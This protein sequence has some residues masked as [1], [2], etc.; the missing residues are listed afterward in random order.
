M[1]QT[2]PDQPVNATERAVFRTISTLLRDGI[3]RGHSA[4]ESPTQ[5]HFKPSPDGRTATQHVDCR[6]VDGRILVE[7][8]LGRSTNVPRM[9]MNSF[10]EI[11]ADLP[12]GAVIPPMVEGTPFVPRVTIPIAAGR[13]MT[14]LREMRIRDVFVDMERRAKLLQSWYRERTSSTLPSALSPLADR[15][16]LVPQAV[17]KS[18]TEQQFVASTLTMLDAG[19]CTISG[20]TLLQAE[21]AVALVAGAHDGP[22]VR[23]LAGEL[24][25]K[26]L[27]ELAPIVGQAGGLLVMSVLG[28]AAGI[29]PYDLGR[30]MA[31]LLRDLAARR[32]PVLF[33]GLANDVNAVFAP[34]GVEPNPLLPVALHAPE[35]EV[36]NLVSFAV[37]RLAAETG[38]GVPE[39]EMVTR[40]VLANLPLQTPAEAVRVAGAAVRAVG[41][42]ALAGTLDPERAAACVKAIVNREEV[43]GGSRSQEPRPRSSP[44]HHRLLHALTDGELLAEHKRLIIGQ[45]AAIDQLYRQLASQ[46]RFGAPEKPLAALMEG[47]PG[48]GK[49]ASVDF[50]ARKLGMEMVYI[51]AAS[52]GSHMQAHSLLLGSGLGIVNS[53]MP[54]KFEVASRSHS[55]LEIADLDHAPDDVRGSVV[56]LFLQLMDR[57]TIQTATGRTLT[58]S[59]MLVCYTCNLPEGDDFKMRRQTGFAFDPLTDGEIRERIEG[60]LGGLFSAAFLSRVGAPI[61]FGP[62]LEEAQHT[63]VRRLLESAIRHACPAVG[64]QVTVRESAVRAVFCTAVG[65]DHS[66]GVRRLAALAHQ[67]L[68]PEIPAVTF[69]PPSGSH[70]VL[71]GRGRTLKLR[72]K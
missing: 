29:P 69:D 12:E 68:L 3:C 38:L 64:T 45:D 27:L 17:P 70:W 10:W 63:I 1:S 47:P 22:V 55:V 44:L 2:T 18:T 8:E 9:P 61:V 32:L 26:E 71:S 37:E 23:P 72:R 50:L 67:A 52:F 36:Q 35:P 14:P 34:Q 40:Q 54:G 41:G 6:L 43:V 66:F 30:V 21:H 48:V 24:G 25:R 60:R 33:L 28:F 16:E 56:E 62:L 59:N 58:S 51:D 53:Y 39:G 5:V 49:S 4:V 46:L 31:Q 19:P 7:V 57:G 11:L 20:S 42:L 13:A 15:L 65:N